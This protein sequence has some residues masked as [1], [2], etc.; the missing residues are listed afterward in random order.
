MAEAYAKSHY[1]DHYEFSSSGVD[2]HYSPTYLS[3]WAR[4]VLRSHGVNAALTP[5]V[6]KLT[7]KMADEAD[8]IIF[9]D[10]SV[11][12]DANSRLRLNPDRYLVWRVKDMEDELPAGAARNSHRGAAVAEHIYQGITR[13]IDVYM[14]DLRHQAWVDVYDKNNE[15]LGY[16]LPI[17]RANELGRW[18]R[19]VHALV[20]T[21]DGRYVVEKR[22]ATIM[23]SPR[24]IDIS[25]GGGVDAGETPEHA[26]LRELSEELGLKVDPSKLRPLGMTTWDTYRPFYHRYTR[27]FLYSFAVTLSEDHPVMHPQAAE[28]SRVALLTPLELRRLLRWRRLPRLGLLLNQGSYYQDLIQRANALPKVVRP[29]L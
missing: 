4:P 26:V 28:V 16:R 27:T 17:G 14:R 21:A 12:R 25:A 9:L 23:Y 29:T 8:L 3:L 19:G 5:S 24:R 18:I 10:A 6:R 22:S 11:A 2:S 1:G 15:P 7:Q 13:R 20:R